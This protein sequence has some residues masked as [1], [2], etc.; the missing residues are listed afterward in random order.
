VAAGGGA[1]VGGGAG[2]GVVIGVCGTPEPGFGVAGFDCDHPLTADTSRK[3]TAS[4]TLGERCIEFRKLLRFRTFTWMQTA[5]TQMAGNLNSPQPNLRACFA[6]Q[7]TS[8]ATAL[9]AL[10]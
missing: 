7:Q 1:G 9:P 6:I 5:A 3:I 10:V 2:F 4:K 8:R